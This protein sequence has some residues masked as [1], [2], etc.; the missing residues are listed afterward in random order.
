M[1][2]RL[3]E[4]VIQDYE[5]GKHRFLTPVE[6]ER[7]QAFPDRWTETGMSEKR[8]YFMMGNALVTKL[9]SMMEPILCKI[10]EAE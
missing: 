3:I 7:L 8:R 4:V 1:K 6:A 10:V 5:T 2:V 9:I